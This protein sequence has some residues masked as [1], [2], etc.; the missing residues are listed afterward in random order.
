MGIA[1]MGCPLLAMAETPAPALTEPS[2]VYDLKPDELAKLLD[3]E[4]STNVTVTEQ[5][6]SNEDPGATAVYITQPIEMPEFTKLTLS[7]R[8][9]NT[10]KD[11]GP[12]VAI[13]VW[14]AQESRYSDWIPLSDGETAKRYKED[15]PTVL[16]RYRVELPAAGQAS[17]S[18]KQSS[19]AEASSQDTP[20][21]R[22]PL[23][24]SQLI[25]SAGEHMFTKANLTALVVVI[26][27]Y[28]LY[29]YRKKKYGA[30]IF[31]RQKDEI[32]NDKQV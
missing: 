24:F 8:C 17:A 3:P 11:Y 27:A 22:Q 16:V 26:G 13:S 7:W 6:I 9:D 19:E 25:V 4:E 15:S 20:H 18:G 32:D 29:L 21:G 28:A 14:K 31:R 23:V 2:Q 1:L 12:G 10:E 5:G 30:D